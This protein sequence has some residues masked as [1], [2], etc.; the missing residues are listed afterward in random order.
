MSEIKV[1]K[2]TF[3]SNVTSLD[4]T[5]TTL[6]SKISDL[7][8]VLNSIPSH[9][10]FGSLTT[11]AGNIAT[12]LENLSTDFD[13]V[14]KSI[15]NYIETL[16]KID[17]EEIGEAEVPVVEDKN[18][19]LDGSDGDDL[20]IDSYN[21]NETS[22]TPNNPPVSNGNPVTYSVGDDGSNGG[23]NGGNNG[24]NGNN[25]TSS[26]NDST[27]PTSTAS[28]VPPTS[29]DPSGYS[30]NEAMG[31]KVTTGHR[32]DYPL[33]EEEYNVIAAIISAEC[34][35]TPDDALAVAS[36]IFNRC[37]DPTWVSYVKSDSPY[38]QATFPNQFV[39]YQGGQ[40]KS[41]MPPNSPKP[42]AKAALDAVLN[43]YR[44]CSYLSF[45]SNGSKSYSNNMI[46]PTG[47][48]YK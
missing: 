10:E 39:V 16:K 18:L 11:K 14:Y 26:P 7:V 23:N 36:V 28:Y 42:A 34:D 30:N 3:E 13:N 45:R 48:R 24:N 22:Q 37:D 46:S 8:S 43:G 47:N 5:V 4:S 21:N 32:T 6:K 29:V 25:S 17:A 44:N 19:T 35:G 1:N 2:S 20:N 41:Y 12:S 38:K 31:F 15:D 9:S 33:T 27:D 40:Y